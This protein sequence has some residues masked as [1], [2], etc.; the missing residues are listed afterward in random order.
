MDFYANPVSTFGVE[1]AI[2]N[3]LSR[4][5]RLRVATVEL[6]WGSTNLLVGQDKPILS[7]REPNSLAQV[8]V[9]PLTGA[10]NPW[11]WQPQARL[12]HRFQLQ[13]CDGRSCAGWRIPNLRAERRC[14]H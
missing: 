9:S 2:S 13:R 3:N 8:G 11:L 6:D 7:P 1:R 12:E 10:G 14:P 5:M 4:L